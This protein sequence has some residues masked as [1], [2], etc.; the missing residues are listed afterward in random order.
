[1][2]IVIA[3]I[4]IVLVAGCSQEFTGQLETNSQGDV[5]F[6][7]CQTDSI[8]LFA[9]ETSGSF[10]VY[11]EDS[12]QL[13]NNGPVIATIEAELKEGILYRPQEKDMSNGRCKNT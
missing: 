10:Y 3:T 1:M 4:I 6:H 5:V 8:Y 9:K 13:Q 7:D 11:L 2:K 12:K